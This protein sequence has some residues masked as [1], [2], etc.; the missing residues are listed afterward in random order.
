MEIMQGNGCP[1]YVALD[2][3]VQRNRQ[4]F[5]TGETDSWHTPRTGEGNT[6]PE[7]PSCKHTNVFLA[8]NKKHIVRP[9]I[10]KRFRKINYGM[11]V[12][13]RAE[14]IQFPHGFKKSVFVVLFGYATK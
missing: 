9:T 5:R 8:K 4:Q 7:T 12:K 10:K 6:P 1:K 13:I 11:H 3:Y 14:K 2:I